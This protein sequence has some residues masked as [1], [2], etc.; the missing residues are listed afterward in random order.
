MTTAPD[1][2]KVRQS[3]MP[4]PQL[5]VSVVALGGIAWQLSHVHAA[6]ELAPLL[7]LALSTLGLLPWVALLALARTLPVPLSAVALAAFAALELSAVCFA[8]VGHVAH[9]LAHY[10]AAPLAQGAFLALMLTAAR[11]LERTRGAGGYGAVAN[12]R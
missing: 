7:A 10:V 5:A 12:E 6:G 9:G 4:W 11:M 1:E 3:G 8:T 2:T